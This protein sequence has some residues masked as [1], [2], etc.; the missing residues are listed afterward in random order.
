MNGRKKPVTDG[1]LRGWDRRRWSIL[2]AT[3]AFAAMSTTAAASTQAC[4]VKPASVVTDLSGNLFINGAV[5]PSGV[6][7]W[8]HLC[9]T[10]VAHNNVSAEACRNWYAAALTAQS[11][12][13]VIFMFFD[14]SQ[15]G[16]VT[17]C[18]LFPAWNSPYITYLGQEN[19]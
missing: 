18:A 15:N 17:N 4:R 14:D 19:D 8:Q 10:A 2:A 7:S 12:G 11:T 13:R 6:W 16:G 1:S 3:A 9:S 5:Q